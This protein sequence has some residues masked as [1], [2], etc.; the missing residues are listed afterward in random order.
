MQ[1]FNGDTYTGNFKNGLVSS[2]ERKIQKVRERERERENKTETWRD[3]Q[4]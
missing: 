1:Y 4:R 3:K 2:E